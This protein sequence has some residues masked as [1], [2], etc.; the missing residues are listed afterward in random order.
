MR[1]PLVVLMIWVT[2]PAKDAPYVEPV[3]IAALHVEV[4]ERL[5]WCG[6]AGWARRYGSA[7]PGGP[8]PTPVISGAPVC[9][10]PACR[11][12]GACG[13]SAAATEGSCCREAATARA[14][15]VRRMS[16]NVTGT[17]ASAVSPVT[18]NAHWKPPVSAAAA[19]WPW[20]S[21]TREWVAATV[22]ATATPIAPPICSEVLSSPEAIPAS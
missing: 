9:A 13:Q 20:P 1:D 3:F 17:A 14:S 21:R 15:S 16:R 11:G 8:H 19:A 7:R 2:V 10:R 4:P 22:D 18:Q 12:A 6:G 5:S